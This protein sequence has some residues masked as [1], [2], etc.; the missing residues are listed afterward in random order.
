[1]AEKAPGDGVKDIKKIADA[2]VAKSK[3]S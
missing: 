3:A 2:V 1:V